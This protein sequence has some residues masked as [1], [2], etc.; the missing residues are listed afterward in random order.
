MNKIR[1]ENIYENYDGFIIKNKDNNKYMYVNTNYLGYRNDIDGCENEL[2]QVAKIHHYKGLNII[3][4]KVSSE[5]LDIEECIYTLEEALEEIAS[6]YEPYK[7]A[8][9]LQLSGSYHEIEM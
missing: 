7:Q 5:Y 4:L 2:Y 3:E 1:L 9:A 8:Q 6:C